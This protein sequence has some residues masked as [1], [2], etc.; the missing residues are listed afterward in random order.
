MNLIMPCCGTVYDD[1]SVPAFFLLGQVSASV[2]CFR[3]WLCVTV[4]I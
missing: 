2:Q 1:L 3:V 4:E